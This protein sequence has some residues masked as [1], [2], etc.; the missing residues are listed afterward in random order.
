MEILV[1][2]DD[3][4]SALKRL[5]K[6]A[7]PILSELKRREAFRCKAQRKKDKQR[8]SARRRKKVLRR[9]EE[10]KRQKHLR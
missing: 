3:I 10:I 1:V 2:G 7:I 5:K 4:E 9:L 8:A 6:K